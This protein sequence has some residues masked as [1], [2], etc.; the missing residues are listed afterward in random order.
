LAPGRA[1][2][3]VKRRRVIRPYSYESRIRPGALLGAIGNGIAYAVF[4]L[5]VLALLLWLGTWAYHA[6]WVNYHCT[7]I[8]GTQVCR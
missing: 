2:V 8:L 1:V 4:G 5:I 6:W 7:L 3:A